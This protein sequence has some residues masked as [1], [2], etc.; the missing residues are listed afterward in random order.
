MTAVCRQSA[1]MAPRGNPRTSK[2]TVL[3]SG[4]EN[5][6]LLRL[7]DREGMS[8]AT[9]IRRMILGAE[10]SLDATRAPTTAHDMIEERSRR[11]LKRKKR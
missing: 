10:G 3:L 5:A 2:F 1:G 11:A 4:R 8:A 7:A 6:A 9:W